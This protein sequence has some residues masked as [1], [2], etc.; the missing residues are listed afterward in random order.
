MKKLILF[1]I[2]LILAGCVS[3]KAYKDAM[4]E[5][6]ARKAELKETEKK[7]DAEAAKNK[8]LS[9]D[10][11][12]LKADGDRQAAQC[13]SDRARLADL[14]SAASDE[15]SAARAELASRTG[16]KEALEREIEA[17]RQNADKV[18]AG[19]EKAVEDLKPVYASLSAGLKDEIGSGGVEIIWASRRLSV[20]ISED[21]IFDRG[22]TEIKPEGFG[23]L[24]KIGAVLKGVSDKDIRVEGHT[25]NTPPGDNNGKRVPS[26]W[27]LSAA[28]AASVARFLSDEAGVSPTLMSAAGYADERPLAS[29]STPEGRSRNRRIAIT[30]LPPSSSAAPEEPAV[31]R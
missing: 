6:D 8:T 16:E 26:N 4:G 28:R 30:L 24:R 22:G 17:L 31:M 27:H 1:C 7:L 25:D 10:L 3:A 2:P 19:R 23:L 21:L 20:I 29:N 18:R 11:V 5:L 13:E 15:L 9:A 12:S 14:N